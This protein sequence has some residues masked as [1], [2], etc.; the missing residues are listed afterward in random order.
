MNASITLFKE[1]H[2]FKNTFLKTFPMFD[3]REV[4][5][6]CLLWRAGA[7]KQTEETKGGVALSRTLKILALPP[8]PIQACWW[9]CQDFESSLYS[10]PSQTEQTNRDQNK[11]IADAW[12]EQSGWELEEWKQRRRREQKTNFVT[13]GPVDQ[14]EN[15]EFAFSLNF[16]NIS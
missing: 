11:K 5:E 2:I 14:P 1:C 7:S 10:C 9:I 6:K 4:D 15:S 13:S 8:T 3:Q 12:Q 16:V